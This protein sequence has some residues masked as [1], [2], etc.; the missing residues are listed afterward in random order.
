M[1]SNIITTDIP[2]YGTVVLA[3]TPFILLNTK[4]DAVHK[5]R[6]KYLTTNTGTNAAGDSEVEVFTSKSEIPLLPKE[7][8]NLLVELVTTLIAED[9]AN[10][11]KDDGSPALPGMS[12]VAQLY[13][14]KYERNLGRDIEHARRRFFDPHQRTFEYITGLIHHDY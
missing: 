2:S 14:S 12:G 4:A 13:R 3:Q 8:H 10:M 7:Y 5:L 1:S 9:L 11:T 6:I